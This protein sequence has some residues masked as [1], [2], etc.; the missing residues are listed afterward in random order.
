MATPDWSSIDKIPLSTAI[1]LLSFGFCMIV[2]VFAFFVAT[3]AVGATSG[4]AKSP[5][6]DEAFAAAAAAAAAIAA[7]VVLEPPLVTEICL[8]FGYYTCGYF[9]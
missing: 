8:A 1:S 4:F 3:G 9:C 5:P 6:N 2:I 7:F